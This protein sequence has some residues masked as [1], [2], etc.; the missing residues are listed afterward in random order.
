M[1]LPFEQHPSEP[2]VFMT[3]SNATAPSFVLITIKVNRQKTHARI[4]DNNI[5]AR[6]LFIVL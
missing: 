2:T 4:W 5:T 1:I 3:V 6:P